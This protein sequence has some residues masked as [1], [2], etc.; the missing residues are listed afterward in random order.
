MTFSH[1]SLQ[2]AS[3]S[4]CTRIR[5][6]GQ[7]PS[8]QERFHAGNRRGLLNV[9]YVVTLLSARSLFLCA[10]LAGA[11]SATASSGVVATSCVGIE[12]SVEELVG[13]EV[14]MW[15]DTSGTGTFL[16]DRYDFAI[17]G[18]VVSV[19]TNDVPDSPGYLETRVLFDVL[20]GYN[21]DSA[22]TGLVVHESDP[23]SMMGYYFVVGATYFVPL[24]DTGPQGETNYSFVCDPIFEVTLDQAAALPS[25]TAVGVS[26]VIPS[27]GSPLTPTSSLTA[28]TVSTVPMNSLVPP[29]LMPEGEQT[30]ESAS[31]APLLA[32]G[33][34]DEGRGG[35]WSFSMREGAAIAVV[36]VA[37]IVTGAILVLSRRRR[38]A[39]T[40]FRLR[41]DGEV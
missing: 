15:T 40:T 16:W 19:E 32:A 39:A 9:Q 7:C 2:S 20:H 24:V 41:S 17:T 22:P 38:A 35:G 4:R 33:Q 1:R 27:A 37:M 14:A 31:T 12:P 3:R 28:T 29:T 36:A 30:P 5:Q 10:A 23:G 21:V 8:R 11:A 6:R 18:T 34:D 13:G 26:V 25:F